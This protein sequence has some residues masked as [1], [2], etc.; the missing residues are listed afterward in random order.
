[1][2]PSLYVNHLHAMPL[3]AKRGHRCAQSV[4]TSKD[5]QEDG[6]TEIQKQGLLLCPYLQASRELIGTTARGGTPPF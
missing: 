5:L 4:G 6:L 3:E 2:P 1:M